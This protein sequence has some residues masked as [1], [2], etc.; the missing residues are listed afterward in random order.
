MAGDRVAVMSENRWEVLSLLLGCA[1]SGAVLVP[2]NTAAR[3]PGLAHVLTDAEPRVLAVEA[4]LEEVVS[5]AP[6]PSG[7][8]RVWLIGGE[9]ES[10]YDGV[11]AEA[12][13]TD[14]PPAD[15]AEPAPG[16]PLAILYTSGTTGRSKGVV[17]PNAQ[18]T[19]WGENVGGWLGIRGDDVLYTC[20][21]LYHT[22]ALNAFVQALMHGA[23]F[24][25]GPRFSA[26]RFWQRIVEADA[27]V[28]YLL[29]TMVSILLAAEPSPR[30]RAHR[31]RVA[32]APA[33]PAEAWRAFEERFGVRLV[34]GHGMTETN[35]AIGPRD[36]VQ[37][38]GSMGR[39]MPGFEARVVD[40]DD[41]EVPDGDARRARGARRRAARLRDG[42]LAAAR[43]DRGARGRDRWFHTGDRVV[44]DADGF[45]RFLD[46]SKDAIRRR[47]ENI[48]GWE[49]E[50]VLLGHPDVATAA[51]VPVPSE[52]GED[53]VMAFV[54]PRGGA[55]VDPAELVRL[56]RAAARPLR[57]PALRRGRRRAAADRERQGAQG[58][59][60]RRAASAPPRGIASAG[61]PRCRR[62]DG[63]P[64]AV[65]LARA[66]AAPRAE[67]A[68]ARGATAWRGWRR[69]TPRSTRSPHLDAEATLAEADAADRALAAG[70]PGA[71]LGL[72]VTVK[73]SIAVAGWPCR[74]GLVGPRRERPGRGR[75]GRRAGAGRRRRSCSARRPCPSTRGR[76]ETESA[77]HGRTRQSLRPRADV[78]AARAAARPRCIAVDASPLGLGYGRLCSIRVPCHFCGI[79]GLRPDRGARAGD[80]RA[81]RPPATR[82]CST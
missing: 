16:D 41:D 33:T 73:D 63:E 71:L 24:V 65:E 31:V 69:R 39:V 8:E 25:V 7:L 12:F 28:T 36:G 4:G 47:G 10:P 58:R 54:V 34:E 29:G 37:R 52:L 2:I 82:A 79:V 21:P 50:Q 51:V 74:S 61:R 55:S 30:D 66:A 75:H 67:R 1:W 46:R 23:E 57:H 56:L 22:N 48:S 13:P 9:G 72:P 32:L 70:E 3:G 49:V 35:A 44:R 11:P 27:T 62:R 78:R 76:T 38:P 26:S 43:G 45:F 64:T 60:P 20:L 40:E 6:A 42:L 68:R 15:S 53:D 80:R 81:G 17:C 59:A 5:A 18:F 14:A 77:L 19:W